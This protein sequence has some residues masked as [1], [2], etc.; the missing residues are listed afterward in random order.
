MAIKKYKK[1]I[2]LVEIIP[3]FLLILYC[4][5][6]LYNFES[7]KQVCYTANNELTKEQ[8]TQEKNDSP[9]QNKIDKNLF[10]EIKSVPEKGYHIYLKLDE[11][12]MYV[13]NDQKLIKT[14]GVSGGKPST[15]SPLG[16]WVITTKDTWGEGFG[17]HWMGFYVPW[18]MYGI[19]GTITPWEIGKYHASEGCIRMNNNDL[20]E[21]YKIIPHGTTVCIEQK[22]R[23]FR[24]LKSGDIGSDVLEVQK[25]L[26]KLGYFNGYA[27]GEFGTFTEEKVRRFQKDNKLYVSGIVNKNTYELINKKVEE[28]Q[29]VEKKL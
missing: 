23:P 5:F 15:P 14:Y 22:N 28:I 27:N 16:T 8:I 3:V 29:K 7:I 25:N 13:F 24:S 21:L 4:A 18:G 10:E 19:H 9:I 1:V 12:K 6:A 17:G 11:L 2:F 26:K 20:K